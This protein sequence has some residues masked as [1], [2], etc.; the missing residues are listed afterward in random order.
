MV[1]LGNICRSP[2]AEG[3]LQ[4]K[5][6]KAG[7]NWQVE[8]AGT[9]GYHTGDPPHP[10]SI[11]VAAANGIDISDQRSRLFTASDFDEFDIIYAM[12]KDVLADMKRL[13]KNKFD[14]KKVSLFLNEQFPGQ[15]LEVP[16]PWNGPESEYREV[17][18]M[19]DTN[20][21]YI[22]KKRKPGTGNLY[23]Q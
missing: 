17:F 4:D 7:L 12:A 19:I 3:V 15:D 20:C 21:E 8:S 1:C 5:A 14:L 13:G 22:V 10:L 16:D 6:L 9:Y 11:K 2:L 23:E 18:K